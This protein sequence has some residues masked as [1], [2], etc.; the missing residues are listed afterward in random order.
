MCVELQSLGS[1]NMAQTKL[2]ILRLNVS[3]PLY[4]ADN[5]TL[6]KILFIYASYLKLANYWQI[7]QIILKRYS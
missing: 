3:K 7:F 4:K 2:F 5:G 1:S 6:L